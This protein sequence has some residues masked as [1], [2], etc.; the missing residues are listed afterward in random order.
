MSACG[1]AATKD[2]S[3]SWNG[4]MIQGM[5]VAARV[6][7]A[8]G[9]PESSAAR[10]LDFIRS[11]LWNDGRLLATFKDGRAHLRAYLDDYVFLADAIVE[12]LQYRWRSADVQ[13]ATELLDGVLEH[14]ADA[15]RGAFFFT[16][17][18]HEALMHRSKTFNDESLPNGNAVAAR[19][20]GRLGHLLGDSRYLAGVLSARCD[21]VG[22]RWS[23]TT[24][25]SRST[26]QR[27]R[28]ASAA[29]GNRHHSRR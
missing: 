14:F 7:Q 4:L 25:R 23:D 3:P 20:F 19:V 11:E 12:L 22:P 24:T 9:S 28:R 29:S 8:R 1:P 10:A 17:D 16:A 27:T 5:A 26:A 18:D 15:E 13:L 6:H 2:T 21:P